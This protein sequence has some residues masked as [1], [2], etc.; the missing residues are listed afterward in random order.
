MQ[1]DLLVLLFWFMIFCVCVTVVVL[2]SI[3]SFIPHCSLYTRERGEHFFFLYEYPINPAPFTEKTILS[4][5]IAAL[6]FSLIKGLHMCEFISGIPVMS[7]LIES[8][9][10]LHQ[11]LTALQFFSSIPSLICLFLFKYHIVWITFGYLVVYI[12]SNPY[13]Y[14]VFYIYST[15]FSS[16][17]L[18]YCSKPSS[19]VFD[20]EM[21]CS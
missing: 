4:H 6:S 19:K 8:I 13:W 12:T 18:A 9:L 10:L 11:T 7:T 15:L 1:C 5:C 20:K 21:K 14:L 17:W 2:A 16:L 3:F